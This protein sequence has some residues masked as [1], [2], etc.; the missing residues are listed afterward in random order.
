MARLSPGYGLRARI[1]ERP[2]TTNA[3]ALA[4]ARGASVRPVCKTIA[5][6]DITAAA[7]F[8]ASLVWS[9]ASGSVERLILVQREVRS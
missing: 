7:P 6:P 4:G 2:T 5:S 1:M 3:A 9:R 8:A